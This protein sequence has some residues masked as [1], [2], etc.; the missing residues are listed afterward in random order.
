MCSWSTEPVTGQ[1]ICC[2][3]TFISISAASWERWPFTPLPELQ[4]RASGKSRK[5]LCVFQRQNV[6]EK[7]FGVFLLTDLGWNSKTLHVCVE[8]DWI[9]LLV[10][11]ANTHARFRNAISPELT[12]DK[13]ADVHTHTHT[14]A[15]K[16]TH[17]RSVSLDKVEGPAVCLLHQLSA[18]NKEVLHSGM[19]RKAAAL[20]MCYA[21][22]DHSNRCFRGRSL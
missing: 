11:K 3:P 15:W 19:E 13:A 18:P 4:S 22:F 20:Y 8:S 16:H 2:L 12:V 5:W 1:F 7:W 10:V 21:A 14:R 6:K 9:L 17:I